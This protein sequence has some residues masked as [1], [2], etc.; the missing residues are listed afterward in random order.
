MSER[1][2]DDPKLFT[3]RNGVFAA[4]LAVVMLAIAQ[5]GLLGDEFGLWAFTKP[6]R[7]FLDTR[8]VEI[9]FRS[10]AWVV[11]GGTLYREVP[12]E[13]PVAANLVFGAV[14]GL[15]A[16]LGPTRDAQTD[17]ALF[18]A[19]GGLGALVAAAAVARRHGTAGFWWAWLLPAGAY[20]SAFRF[21]VYPALACVVAF[22][23]LR[24]DR[25][26]AAAMAL[27]VCIAL[28]GYALVAVPAL[29]FYVYSRRGLAAAAKCCAL[30]ALP[31]AVTALGALPFCGLDGLLS[32]FRFHA[33][34][35]LNGESTWDALHLGA[36]VAA[37]PA[38]PAL[39]AAAAGLG[40]A[41]MR[42]RTLE[43]LVDACLVAVAGF[44][45]GSVFYSPQFSL[46]LLALACFSERR[47]TLG[48]AYALCVASYLHFP[49]GYDLDR[50]WHGA[51]AP[52]VVLVTLLRLA[53]VAVAAGPQFE[54]PLSA[55]PERGSGGEAR[56]V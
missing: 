56:P 54:S 42:P 37:V 35:S 32:A 17:F 20:F 30:G 46:W 27:G 39:V 55:K 26:D 13:Y 14:R 31:S 49:V 48:L 50:L 25:F 40:A 8:D 16:L 12:S 18:W 7:L 3:W 23:Y 44:T 6:V 33:Q 47:A 51:L 5:H 15:S 22:A 53:L 52:V 36:A 38:L 2:C 9:Y 29:L 10:S 28:K 41:A 21:D 1:P 24:R 4:W 45:L 11:G 43:R 34:R 19:L